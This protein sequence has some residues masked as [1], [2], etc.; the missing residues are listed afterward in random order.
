MMR[1]SVM[2]TEIEMTTS[3]WLA[4]IREPSPG[5][6]GLHKASSKNIGPRE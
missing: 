4:E 3:R 6:T 1:Q 5:L 2:V